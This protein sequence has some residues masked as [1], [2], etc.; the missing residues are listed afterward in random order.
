MTVSRAEYGHG[1]V[2]FSPVLGRIL[3]YN[4]ETCVDSVAHMV[5]NPDW[6]RMVLFSHAY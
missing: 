5:G 4:Q 2:L 3:A 1:Q 6:V